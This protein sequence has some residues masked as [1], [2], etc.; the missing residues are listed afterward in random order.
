VIAQHD[1]LMSVNTAVEIDLYGQGNGDFIDGH[2]YSGS[3]GSLIS[4]KEPRSPWAESLFHRTEIVR[5]EWHDFEH[6]TE[7][8]YGHGHAQGRGTHRGGIW[9]GKPAS[10][11]DA[12]RALASCAPEFSVKN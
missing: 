10:P 2:P 9:H 11:I 6:R 1:N 12:G 5:E 7:G 3:G 4:S 8:A